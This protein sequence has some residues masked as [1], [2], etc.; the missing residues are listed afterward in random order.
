MTSNTQIV[1]FVKCLYS[2]FRDDD[3]PALGAQLTYYLILSFFPFLIFMVSL[4][5]FI[6]LSG[7]SVVAELIRLLPSEASETISG[8][9]TEVVDNSSGTL[10]SFGMIATIWSASNGINAIVKGL[11]KAY[12]VEE[13][14]PFWKVRGISL[15]ATV[16]LVVVIMLVMLMLIFGKAIGEYLFQ[17][18]NY[19]DGFQWIWG[20]LKYAI[21]ITAMAAA[22]TLLYW[23]VPSRRLS[24][25]EAL[26][27]AVFATLG[28]IITSL[29]F[30]FY[31]NNFG[32]YSKT[33]GSL[34]GMIIL[35]IWLYISSILIM[36]GGEINATLASAKSNPPRSIAA[37]HSFRFPESNGSKIKIT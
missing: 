14:R 29:A 17:W 7:D 10:L 25:K 24:F 35:L 18:M 16:F 12:D 30:Q 8:I 6:E 5:G 19:P 13:Q 2:R 21:P 1:Q 37:M 22:F 27:G 33:Y 4:L 20:I 34:G 36:L 3:V 26:P 28:W 11:N 9:L 31:M 23:M 32:N 15:L